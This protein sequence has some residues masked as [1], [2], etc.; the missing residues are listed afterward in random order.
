MVLPTLE[1]ALPVWFTSVHKDPN[2]GRWTGSIGHTKIMDKI[3]RLGCK[4]ITGAYRSMATDVLEL[5]A[6]IPLTQICLDNICHREVLRLATLPS[7]HPLYKAVQCSSRRCPRS[8]HWEKGFILNLGIC[9]G[10]WMNI[11]NI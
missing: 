2:T 8:H 11:Q 9:I 10:K 6:W 4:L 1:Y 3:L 5:H 7:S